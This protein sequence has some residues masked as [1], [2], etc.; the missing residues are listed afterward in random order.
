MKTRHNM[1]KFSAQA[2]AR[3]KLWCPLG[4]IWRFDWERICLGAHSSCWHNSVPCSCRTEVSVCSVVVDLRS[5]S[6]PRSHFPV[7][8]SIFK[9]SSREPSWH[10]IPL[11]LPV[12]SS[13]WAESP[14]RL[15]W[16]SQAHPGNL[17]F[18]VSCAVCHDLIKGVI[19]VS[20]SQVPGIIQGVWTRGRNLR[21]HHRILST[22]DF[23][24]L[25]GRDCIENASEPSTVPCP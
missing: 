4:L 18:L 9:T 23:K 13:G 12:C 19:I 11:M 21:G 10:W 24:S 5:L 15:T 2:L 8:L 1:T 7:S 17:P 6:I 20:Q 3:L 22:T 25:E 14:L 16:F